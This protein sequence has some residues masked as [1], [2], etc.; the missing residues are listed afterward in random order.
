MAVTTSS[1]FCVCE[2]WQRKADIREKKKAPGLCLAL[3][4]LN[5]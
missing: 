5:H 1:R 3:E 2:L 4:K